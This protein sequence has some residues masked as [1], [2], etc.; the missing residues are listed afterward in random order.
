MTMLFIKNMV[1]PRCI[2]TVNLL[3][4]AA[5]L[6]V[7]NVQLGEVQLT[8]QPTPEQLLE[9]RE[10][11]EKEG[12]ELLDDRNSRL[13]AQIKALVIAEIHH[14]AGRRPLTMNFSEF[15]AKET[16]HEYGQ[17]SRLFSAVEG[18]TIE[19][20]II[21]QKIERAKELLLYDELTITEI[22]HQME[23][24]SPQHLSNQFRQVTGLTPSQFKSN[25]QLHRRKA[26]D[27]V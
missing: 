13:V 2:R 27:Q 7:K 18:L 21:A 9:L 23:Y 22:A 8:A 17:M 16:L 4:T 19:K 5:G 20:F 24:S 11:L 3:L 14:D 15:L 1:C 26:L 12:F 6:A 10:S 25:H